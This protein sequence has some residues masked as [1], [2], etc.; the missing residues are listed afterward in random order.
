M[1]HKHKWILNQEWDANVIAREFWQCATCG[2]EVND[3]PM[4]VVK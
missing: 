3:I 2:A 1:P 4:E